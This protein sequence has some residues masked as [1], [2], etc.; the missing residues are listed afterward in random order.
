VTYTPRF[1]ADPAYLQAIGQAFYNY[2]YLEMA[3]VHTI[4]RL[5]SNGPRRIRPKAPAGLLATVLPEMIENADPA[6][7][8]A[9]ARELRA[10]ARQFTH[11][12]SVRHRLLHAWPVSGPNEPHYLEYRADRVWPI[13]EVHAAAALFEATALEGLRIYHDRLAAPPPSPYRRTSPR[14]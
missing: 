9:V 4:A 5:R 3:V 12:V 6:L 8:A 1:T 14:T 10:F 7:D 2:A 11:A 13:A